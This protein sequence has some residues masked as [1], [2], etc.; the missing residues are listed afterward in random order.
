MRLATVHYMDRA[1]AIRALGQSKR[2]SFAA[3]VHRIETD[4]VGGGVWDM[5]LTDVQAALSSRPDP[6]GRRGPVPV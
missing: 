6:P 3:L 2:Q 4:G 5:G 1:A